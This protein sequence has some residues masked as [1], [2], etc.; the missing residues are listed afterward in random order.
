V[1]R[2]NSIKMFAKNGR[3]G[4]KIKMVVVETD[5]INFVIAI[6]KME[7]LILN[8]DNNLDL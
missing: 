6:T 2:T 7:R 3:F 5:K 4:K 8:S 1:K